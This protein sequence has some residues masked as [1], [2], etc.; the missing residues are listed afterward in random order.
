[1]LELVKQGV[2]VAKQTYQFGDIDMENQDVEIPNYNL[3]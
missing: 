1:M 2:I 3:N